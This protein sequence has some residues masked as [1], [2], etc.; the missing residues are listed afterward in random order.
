[1]GDFTLEELVEIKAKI[2]SS[3]ESYTTNFKFIF[4]HV[5]AYKPLCDKKTAEFQAEAEAITSQSDQKLAVEN[6]INQILDSIQ[7]NIQLQ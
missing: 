1:M 7:V 6:L 2:K 3:I 4:N 5:L